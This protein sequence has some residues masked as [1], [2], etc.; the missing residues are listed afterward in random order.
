L[1]HSKTDTTM[2]YLRIDLV[3]LMKCALP[4]SSIPDDF[5]TQKGGVFYEQAI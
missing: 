4:V 5:Y 2:I 3:S 1:G